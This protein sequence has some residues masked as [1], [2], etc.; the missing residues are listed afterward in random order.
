[1]QFLTELRDSWE[2]TRFELVEY[3]GGI[4]YLIRNWDPL[5][6]YL[7]D[8]LADL[9]AMKTSPYF[10]SFERDALI[11]ENK[12]NMAQAIFDLLV[13]IQRRWIY[14]Y[15]IFM[16]S[17][18]VQQQLAVQYKKFKGFDRD[19]V[20]LMR[21]IHKESLVDSW[22]PAA[23]NDT[24][25]T[26]RR[27]LLQ[28]LQ[29]YSDLLNHIQKALGEYLEKQRSAFPRFYFVGDED[30]LEIIGNANNPW[31]IQRHLP[32]MFAGVESLE[33]D[34]TPVGTTNDSSNNKATNASIVLRAMVSKEGEIVPFIEPITI[35]DNTSV[36]NWL[37]AVTYQMRYTLSVL[38]DRSVVTMNT[39]N[40]QA[41]SSKHADYTATLQSFFTWVDQY[42]AQIVLLASQV[43][44]T[45][46][47]ENT[48]LI[49]L[50]S[51]D[52]RLD[53]RVGIFITMNP[54]YAG[55]SELPDNLKQ[56]FRSMAMIAPDRLL[57]SQ[58][59]LY[60]QGFRTAE[61]LSKSVTL[62]FQLCS[63]QLSSRS[64][65]D[66]GL[67][68]LKSVLRSA[69]GLKRNALMKKN[70]TENKSQDEEKVKMEDEER[71]KAQDEKPKKVLTISEEE[72]ALMVRAICAT[73]VPKLVASD[74]TLF[75]TLV[76]AVFPQCNVTT[77]DQPA[78][79]AA[80]HKLASSHHY[81][82]CPQWVE[83]IMQLHEI[84][85]I[86]HG[87]IMVGPSSGKTAAWSILKKAM[88]QVHGT[89]IDTY[90][91]DAK[92]L[93]S[94]GELFGVL[95]PTT[96]E[97]SEGIFTHILRNILGNMK[98]ESSR[99][100]WIIFD[101]DIDPDWVESMN[102][103][104]DDNK[105]LTLPN[106]ERLSLTD[107]IRVMFEV[108]DLD[109]ATPATVSRCGMVWFSADVV[110]SPMIILNELGKLL[111]QPLDLVSLKPS[112]YA[113][114][115]QVQSQAVTILE[116]LFGVT[117]AKSNAP[118]PAT[119]YYLSQQ[120]SM[121]NSY[122][123]LALE[124]ANNQEHIMAFNRVQA[125]SAL[126]S[127]LKGGIARVME[128]NDNHPDFP[129][130]EVQLEAF[131]SKYLVY[132]L[133]WSFG[134]SLSLKNRLLF[135]SEL[136]ILCP[137]SITLPDVKATNTAL[138]DYEV[139]VD[140]Q[141]WVNYDER[142]D[143]I[144]IETHQVIR[145][146]V[147][148][149]TVDTARHT[150]IISCWV[151]DHR[152]LILCGP[153][154]SG[155]SMTLTAVLR[156]LPEFDLVTLNF[157]S[158]TS[159]KLILDT[160]SHHCVVERTPHGLVMK[161]TSPNK[162][163]C[164]FADEINLPAADKY[165][166][167]PVITFLRQIAEQ[168]GFWRA[169]DLSFIRLERVQLIGA[170]NPPTD[171]GRVVLTP[172]FLRHCPL[173][174]VDYPAVPSLRQIYG[175]FNRALLKLT[176]SLRSY[177]EPLTEAMIGVYSQSQ[178]RFTPDIQAHYIYSPRELSRW[179]RAMYEA[180]KPRSADHSI[181]QMTCE[182]LVRLW[183][184]EAL[185][186]FQDRLVYPEERKWTDEMI[187]Q[188]AQQHFPTIDI[189]QALARPVLFSNWTTKHYTSVTQDDLRTEVKNRLRIFYEEELDVKLVL[190]DEV[191]EYVLRIDRVLRQPLGHL[192]LVGS[193][194][195]GKTILSK[196]VAWRNN[197]SIFQIK[198]H[199][200]YTAKDFDK[201]LRSILIR[202]GCKNETICF[203]FD[204]SNVLDTSFLER[205][206][207]LLASGEVPGLFEGAEYS[208]LMLECKEGA[209]RDGLLLDTED[210]LYRHFVSQVQRNLHVVFTQN[211]ANEDFDNR[212]ATSPALFNR[213]VISWMGEWS[214][215]ALYQV[216]YEF[217]KNLDLGDGVIKLD[218]EEDEE[219]ENKSKENE[220]DEDDDRSLSNSTERD[221]V[222][223][224]LVYVHQ[225]VNAAAQQLASVNAGRST[226]ITPRH[227]LDFIN[228]YA[229]LFHEKR[230]AL[231]EQQKHLKTGLRKLTETQ[232]EVL[233]LQSALQEKE[234]ELTAKKKLA[235]DK[236]EQIMND[237]REAESKRDISIQIGVE[238]KQQ[239]EQ[240]AERRDKVEIEL[241]QAKPALEDAEAAVRNIK[242]P[243]LDQV[244]RFLNPPQP[245][246]LALEAIALMLGETVSP[247]WNELR[248]VLRKADFIKSVIDYDINLLND[249][250]RNKIVK[251]YLPAPDFQYDVVYNASKA[252]GPLVKWVAST[253]NFSRIKN[254]VA[255][256]EAELKAVAEKQNELKNKQNELALMREELSKRID[257]YKVEYSDLIA[258]VE[259]IKSE[260][261]SV[262]QKVDRSMA[263]L[264]NL[265]SERGRWEADAEAFETQ[266]GSVVGDCLLS[267]AFLS[268]I[269]YFNQTYRQLLFSTWQE[270]L[271]SSHVKTKL[272][273][274][275][276]EYL[277][278]PSERLE[279]IKHNLPD[280]SLCQENGVI[281]KRF[282]RYPLIIDPSGQATEFIMNHY[283]ER[284]ILRTSFLDDAFLKNLE[285]ALRFGSALLVEDV[286]SIDPILNSVLNREITKTGGRVLIT[287]GDKEIDFSPSFVIFLTT[288]D[289]SSHFTPDLCSRVTFV[290][291]TVTPSS[292][293]SQ[294]LSKILKAERKDIDTKRNDLLQLQGGFKVKLRQLEDSLLDALNGVKGNILENETVLASLEKLK[295]EA[296]E[297]TQKMLESEHVMEEITTV[298]NI[299]RPF[300]TACSSIYFSL[301][302]LADVHY[303]YQ[304]SLPF[305]LQIVDQLLF[306]TVVSATLRDEKDH[307]KRLRHLTSTL[308]QSSYEKVSR[309]ML[310]K[311]HAGYAL[312]LA[313]IALEEANI[314][315]LSALDE[316][317][318]EFFMKGQVIDTHEHIPAFQRLTSIMS[319][320]KEKSHH[321]HHESRIPEVPSSLGP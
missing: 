6:S 18:D 145:A 9:S 302:K 142:V 234:G 106:G 43:Y 220:Y 216:G 314:N 188:V 294:C 86:H 85:E 108:A 291:F 206:N 189:R 48:N 52:V 150:D 129:L 114:W 179:V 105:L 26:N 37:T 227:Y 80:V 111:H 223:S 225:S 99:K 277:S 15:G 295:K 301:E 200:Y 88:E 13:D 214:E 315:G 264:S 68:A 265:S 194:G 1:M 24:T 177:S 91:I 131:F 199:K 21:D 218:Y 293:T 95:D 230:S 203:I 250:I 160:L 154:G 102:S 22:I 92:A 163:L 113:R 66:F 197:M 290:N 309:A 10:K 138:L 190:F 236:L 35:T 308:F 215:K 94:K 299:Y 238:I 51:K 300:A 39:W 165:Q 56:L 97:L 285:S 12:L 156:A 283:K 297:V 174:F 191:L 286:E 196:F 82:A 303:L 211:P 87:I 278:S 135:C 222:V 49:R 29:A 185:R 27:N 204:E 2:Q 14:L 213:C 192:L 233:K 141:E 42:P 121:T 64:H 70:N 153:P 34:G 243:D 116:N 274:S 305:F 101:G 221:A 253:I 93:Q 67:R 41:F 170:C 63:A 202:S 201:D 241:A 172:R 78:L 205:M 28:E 228:H 152:P 33:I 47:R 256:L 132:S 186:L 110:T 104:L 259:R 100:H 280:D 198:V 187:D 103:L 270:R 44:F 31:K 167:Q 268:Y 118:T 151:S 161:P 79:R 235:N 57:I 137:P 139:R 217:T 112:V 175:T 62:L 289:P 316:K 89:K 159:P 269:G 73:I 184:H 176:P 195:S 148:I 158:T 262:Q 244:S 173:L 311:D 81:E 46:L 261:S 144:E 306:P 146:D 134:G 36:H 304:F 321:V 272:D 229:S 3:R 11:W 193:S 252:C 16:N 127:L 182:E 140:S 171:A 50:N 71:L 149:D 60:S 32:K 168:G 30:L 98:N 7:T 320:Q 226:Y 169:S 69:G 210:E 276:V 40:D 284:K 65:Y 246:K 55:R 260:M 242:K 120:E 84:Q 282:H 279:W 45:G 117:A 4:N 247:D 273:I 76:Q 53:S 254:S 136:V 212:A 310:Q 287:L 245:V 61:E 263:L 292:L 312:R 157:S 124:W 181:P 23:E 162:W 130:N 96:A 281:L 126:F 275:L 271:K 115:K 248:K 90:I 59:M 38:L 123:M 58:V 25:S 183:L 257:Q 313:Q 54:G 166:T 209:R 267:A 5:F 237:Q 319:P 258:E 231:E 8:K 219:N 180:I 20:R 122:V 17:V 178:A 232:E 208:N 125:L 75:S 298:S 143:A 107:N 19:F 296:A 74:V 133:I 128:Y 207:A 72:Q 77:I 240:I 251:E 164:I 147:V 255:P 83:K 109:H 239:E 224:S 318:V 155:K 119:D 288:R 266:I 249:K 317:E 307:M